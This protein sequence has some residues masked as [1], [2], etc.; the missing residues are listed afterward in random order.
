MSDNTVIFFS[1]VMR[2][3]GVLAAI[4]GAVYLANQGKEGW[5]WMI[6]LAVLLG[7]YSLKVDSDKRRADTTAEAHKEGS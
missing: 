3:L 5:G 1:V 7:S 6:F 4:V 2:G